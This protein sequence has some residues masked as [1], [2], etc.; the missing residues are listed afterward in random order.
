M[1]IRCL[2][3]GIAA[4]LLV[5]IAIQAIPYGRTASNPPVI[6]EPEWDTS[7]TRDLAVRACFDCHSN[8]THWPWYSRMAPVT[9]WTL[10]HV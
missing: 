2:K 8:E 9:W 5:L 10:D 4:L 3:Y 7:V 1:V 6:S